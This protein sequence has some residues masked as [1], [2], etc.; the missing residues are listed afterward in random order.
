MSDC[1]FLKAAVAAA[2][3]LLCGVMQPLFVSQS[4]GCKY[5]NNSFLLHV[6]RKFKLITKFTSP[7]NQNF[8]YSLRGGCLIKFFCA[9]S[10]AHL[11]RRFFT[12]SPCAAVSPS[13]T[14]QKRSIVAAWAL[15]P[16]LS[17]F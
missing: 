1:Q 4:V 11:S 7:P 12:P 2:C 5:H 9:T 15:S 13:V 17:L 14:S 10:V 6:L 3:P 8:S 16:P